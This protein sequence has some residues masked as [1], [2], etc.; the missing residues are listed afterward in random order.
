MPGDKEHSPFSCA[1]DERR[2]PCKGQSYAYHHRE[3]KRQTRLEHAPAQGKEHGKQGERARH[4][5]SHNADRDTLA[6]L[7][8][9]AAQR[10]KK[11]PESYEGEQTSADV[12][13]HGRAPDAA[14]RTGQDRSR[15]KCQNHC[16][17]DMREGERPGNRQG[18]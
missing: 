13:Q 18:A 11:E 3:S 9:A 1:H 7:V 15:G 12:L 4:E 8:R 6:V 16:R 2:D 14:K 17:A 10:A 5:T